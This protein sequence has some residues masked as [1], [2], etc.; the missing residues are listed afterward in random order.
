MRVC[1]C[2][3]GSH[4]VRMAEQSLCGSVSRQW[5]RSDQRR[6][7]RSLWR[8]T[9]ARAQIASE[10]SLKEEDAGNR[11]LRVGGGSRRRGLRTVP[12]HHSTCGDVEDGDCAAWASFELS[13]IAGMTTSVSVSGSSTLPPSATSAPSRASRTDTA[14]SRPPAGAR[15]SAPRSRT[16]RRA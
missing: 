10:R 2:Q 11:A 15:R 16:R 7:R 1:Q 4:D 5:R 14:S 3:A 12:V 13:D 9:R 8:S 6:W